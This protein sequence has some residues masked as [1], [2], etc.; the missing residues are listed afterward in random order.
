[1][2]ESG[3]V[4]IQSHA[5]THTWYFS[6]PRIIDFHRP[7]GVDG[8]HAPMWL[9]WNMFPGE[10]YRSMHERLGERIP[11]GTP[12]Y[13]HGKSFVGRRYFE[14]P[15]LTRRLAAFVGE[16][17][18]AGF[19]ARAGWRE[20]LEAVARDHGNRADRVET[21]E[22]F[23][24]RVRS[25]LVESRQEIEAALGTK[26]HFLCWPGGAHSES[27]VA[28][29]EETGYL[30][31]TTLLG[32]PVRKNIFGEDP[33]IIN[34]IGSGSPW[35]WRGAFIKHTSPEFFIAGF[36]LFAGKPFSI[37]KYRGYKLLYALRY[38]VTGKT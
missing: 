8:Y 5:K 36:D 10:K 31:T 23:R 4:E 3:V 26:V 1:M 12:I 28:M 22:E 7:E 29:A 13:E 25:E 6:G 24:S 20:K 32:D 9:A 15:A 2:V 34:R 21:D 35:M 33:R 27:V 14:D 18:G 37:W 38:C 11:Y 16:N 19:F 17:G 30:A